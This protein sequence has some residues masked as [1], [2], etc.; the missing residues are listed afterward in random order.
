MEFKPKFASI[1][2]LFIAFLP[3]LGN[4]YIGIPQ[5]LISDLV[6]LFLLIAAFQKRKFR[7][8]AQISLGLLLF[9]FWI[10]FSHLLQGAASASKGNINELSVPL[11]VIFYYTSAIAIAR[12]LDA[13]DSLII[14]RY[15]IIFGIIN[16]LYAIT[17]RNLYSLSGMILPSGLPIFSQRF[18]LDLRDNLEVITLNFG[19]R[20]SGFFSE[21]AHLSQY[22]AIACLLVI[23]SERPKILSQ[24]YYI[25]IAIITLLS[26]AP[27][28]I[29]SGTGIF[30]LIF[31]LAAIF[32]KMSK[33]LLFNRDLGLSFLKFVVGLIL[34]ALVVAFGIDDAF[35][36]VTN[37]EGDSSPLFVRV[38]RPFL[39]F[40]DL[41]EKSLFFEILFGSGFGS[42]INTLNS[43]GIS[44]PY[45][46]AVDTYWTNTFGLILSS[47]GLIGFFVFAIFLSA[48]ARK[49]DIA[50]RTCIFFIIASCFFSDMAFSIFAF[51]VILLS[52]DYRQYKD[53]R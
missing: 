46:I 26:L 37:L 52:L 16:A 47:I 1:Q 32:I 35:L 34:T 33:S 25:R 44:T 49:S 31:L 29:G 40:S 51:S 36:R 21:P 53:V 38:I 3:V 22:L 45:E 30:T 50:G 39:Y 24:H 27:L 18:N 13:Y 11:R 41:Y 12:R 43:L 15:F 7:S 4:Y 23:F 14:R 10:L 9:S 20:P 28:V 2:A 42:Y 6:V 17:Q 5:L 19:Y 48:F 8:N